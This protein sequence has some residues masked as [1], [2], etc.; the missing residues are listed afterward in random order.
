L[1]S[2][3]NVLRVAERRM[4]NHNGTKDPARPSRKSKR[5]IVARMKKQRF[6]RQGAKTQTTANWGRWR[7][8]TGVPRIERKKQE[9]EG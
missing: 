8:Q 4:V 3:V 7:A 1:T 6:S 9:I 5:Q 2:D